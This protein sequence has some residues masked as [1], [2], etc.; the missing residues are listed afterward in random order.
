MNPELPRENNIAHPFGVTPA[1]PL[2]P[3]E[4]VAVQ[5]PENNPDSP[6]ATAT[7]RRRVGNVW[8][9]V[10]ADYKESDNRLH[11]LAAG[12]G[13]VALQAA[14]RARTSVVLVPTIAVDVLQWTHSP[15]EAALTAGAAFTMWCT[16]VG[17]ATT[18]GL[19]QFP[20]ASKRV[21]TEFPRLVGAFEDSL[22][23]IEKSD[24]GA[25]RAQRV[26][27][28]ALM[29]LRRGFTVVGLGTTAYVSTAA[30]K[31]RKRR[32]IHELN[33]QAS[34]DGGIAAGLIVEGV[35]QAIVHLATSH[36]ELAERIQNDASNIKLWYGVTAA[37]MIGQYG[38][39]KLKAWRAAKQAGAEQTEQAPSPEDN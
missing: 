37:M 14:D 8:E 35:G 39:N 34:L 11:F 13:M 2:V 29:A 28:R 16:A 1:S 18:E 24:E 33:L 20:R 31:G 21:D 10:V 32:D 36:P 38:G 6:A 7:L 3:P 22:P 5:A 17:G 27:G 25:N 9:S 30:A 4:G 26:G 12:V 19:R 15:L 23:G